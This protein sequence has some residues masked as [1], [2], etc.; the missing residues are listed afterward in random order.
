MVTVAFGQ[1]GKAKVEKSLIG[2]YFIPLKV[3]YEHG[4][5]ESNT[6]ELSIGVSGET[7]FENDV[8]N[9]YFVPYA[10]VAVKNYYNLE[11]R[12][13]LLPCGEFN[14]ITKAISVLDWHWVLVRFLQV[15][16]HISVPK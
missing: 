2:V 5:G 16:G 11:K 10:A 9:F 12:Y 1:T 8:V 13:S 7:R 6:V 3:S 14:V 4:I 15:M